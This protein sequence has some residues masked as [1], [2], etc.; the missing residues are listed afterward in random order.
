MKTIFIIILTFFITSLL[1]QKKVEKE[2]R[3]SQEMVPSEALLF[4]KEVYGSTEKAKW[5]YEEDAG[6]KSFE[7]KIKH[8]N[9]AHSIEFDTLG[10][11][12]D[13]EIIIDWDE[14]PDIA[15]QN[16]E[17]HLTEN[18][19]KYGIERIQMQI[20]GDT[21]TIRKSI[22]KGEY[23]RP[24]ILRF[25]IEYLGKIQKSHQLWEGLFNE[26]GLFIEKRE[27]ELLPTQNLNY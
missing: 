5:Y 9:H 27:V 8:N 11:L 3:I 13:I 25:E 26:N 10:I 20:S 23:Y 2:Y 17:K 14:I 21:E 7:A 6:K 24:D 19:Q 1:A 16:I 15:K 22:K 4:L 18:Y 12:E